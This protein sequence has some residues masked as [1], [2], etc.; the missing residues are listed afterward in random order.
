MA[1]KRVRE[2]YTVPEVCQMMGWHKAHV[3][4][5]IRKGTFPFPVIE[6][7]GKYV[8]SKAAVDRFIKE[9]K[10]PNYTGDQGRPKR[11]IKGEYKWFHFR[12]PIDL[13]EE[14]EAICKYLNSQMDSPIDLDDYRRIAIREFV[15]RRPIPEDEKNG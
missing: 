14:F 8:V 2:T 13:A 1:V 3:Y 6:F 10:R 4:E 11:W 15:Q 7:Q 12:V 5:H 9:Q